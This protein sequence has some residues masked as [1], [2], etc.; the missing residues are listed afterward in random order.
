MT[1]QPDISVLIVNWN[2]RDITLRCLDHLP[3]AVDDD[4]EYEVIVVDNGSVDGSAAAFRDR[5]DIELIEN[6]ANLGF[7]LAVNQAYRH[8]SANL[9][10]LLNSDVD[11]SEGSLSTLTAFLRDHPTVAGVAPLYENP[12]GSRQPFHFRLPTFSMTLANGSAIFRRLLPGSA[13]LLAEYKMLDED[14]SVPCPVP[15]PSA[16]CLLL[17]RSCLPADHVLDECYPIYFNDVQLARSLAAKG[18]QLWA[19]PDAVVTHEAHASGNLVDAR[20][21]R[22]LYLA[23]VIRMLDETE[24]KPKVALYRGVVVIQNLGLLVL[25]RPGALGFRELGRVLAGDPGPLPARPDQ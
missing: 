21:A 9:V 1:T 19:T 4:L 7:A 3:S 17:R 8:S 23:S 20:V 16:S 15:Q 10:L 13:R 18:F 11:M 2:T 6:T 12:D 14:F 22:R 24:S 25:R 5:T